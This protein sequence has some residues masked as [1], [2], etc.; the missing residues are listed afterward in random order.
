[1]LKKPLPIA[2]STLPVIIQKPAKIKLK[3]IAGNA[4]APITCMLSV[5]LKKPRRTWGIKVNAKKPKSIMPT[6]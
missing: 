2:W 3:L 5:A 1:M 4:F 6:A